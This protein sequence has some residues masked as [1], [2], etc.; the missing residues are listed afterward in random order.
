MLRRMAV[1]WTRV[2]PGLHEMLAYRRSW[3][4]GDVVAGLTVVAY[5]VPQVMAYAGV[6][7]L[8][9][10]AGLWAA[11]P[12]VAVYA[13]LGSSRQLSVGPESTTALMAAAAIGPLVAGNPRRYAAMAAGLAIMVGLICVLAW[14]ARLGFIADL[15]SRPVLIG[16]LAGVAVIMIIGQLRRTTGVPVTGGTLIREV[17]SFVDGSDKVR[18][19]TVLL[20]ACVLAFLFAAQTWAPKLPGPLLAVAISAVVVGVFGLKDHGLSV[21]GAVPEGLPSAHLP[22][23]TS[24]DLRSL[25]L[26]AVGIAVV[27]Y[28]DNVLTARA[29]ASRGRY[30]IDPNQELLAL[31]VANVGAGLVRGFPVSSSGSRTALGDSAGSRTQ[32]HSLVSL[33]AL[34]LVL[35]VGG[36]ALS[37]FPDAALGAIIVFAASRLVD[38][39]EFKR[40]A[41]FRRSELFLALTATAGVLVMDILYGVLIAVGL[42]VADL[43]RRVARPHDAILGEVAGLAGMHDVDDY[44]SARTIPGLVIYR[45]DSPL[46]FANAEDFKRRAL[47]AAESAECAGRTR[48]SW[49]VLNVEAIVEVDI[50]GLDAVEWLRTEL[51]RRGIV[52]AMAR[53]KQDLL[54][55]L[56]ASG[57][58]ER[59]G[60]ER[61]FPTLPTAVAAYRARSCD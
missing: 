29:F 27:G 40:I 17:V 11:V 37:N 14:V 47:A 31:G 46:F 60:A 9:P 23:L 59:I 30:E 20:S 48:P 1:R 22:P 58:A 49:F 6:A 44:R 12:A 7:G 4:R 19:G 34:V 10:V 32:L 25:A 41:R 39:A 8:P 36:T 38:V 24:G 33:V 55:D 16:Y 18:V 13:V 15:L 35:L 57:L 43:L 51:D 2:L 54:D 50:T 26:P 21:I 5:L 56:R 52:M 53:V 3:L 45:Y 42:S 28:T 61:L